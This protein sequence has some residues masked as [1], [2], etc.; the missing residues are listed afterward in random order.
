MWLFAVISYGAANPEGA[1]SFSVGNQELPG[2]LAYGGLRTRNSPK[3]AKFAQANESGREM[4]QGML[5]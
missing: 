5:I 3:V 2:C 1:K 4:E